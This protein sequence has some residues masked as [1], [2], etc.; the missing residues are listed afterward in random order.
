MTNRTWKNWERWALLLGV[1]AGALSYFAQRKGYLYHRYMFVAFLLLWMGVELLLA[2]RRT[3][4]AR[5]VGVAGLTLGG[6][7]FPPVYAARIRNIV[8]GN[9]YSTELEHD[10]MQLGGAS[11]D[12]R[13]QC[14]D[15]VDGCFNALYHDGLVQATGSL[16]DLL[17]FSR[18]DGPIVATYRARFREELER[19]PPAVIIVSNEWFNEASSF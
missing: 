6:L 18:T 3:G 11:L 9:H 13:V 7:I 16:G 2:M 15:M 19:N 17:Y 8:V 12:R 4:W 1:A 5:V 10:L 14:L